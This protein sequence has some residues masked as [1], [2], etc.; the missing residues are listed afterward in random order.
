M[1]ETTYAGPHGELRTY[2]SV[3]PG[4]GP[5]PGVVLVHDILGMT[6]DLRNH[7]DRFAANGYLALAPDLYSWGRKLSCLKSTFA[8]LRARHGRA[9]DDIEAARVALSDRQDC[10]G[11]VGVIGYCMGGGFALL[12]APRF[13]FDA[14]SVNYGDVPQDAED[15]LAGTCPIVGSFGGMD[16]MPKPGTGA[17]L[18]RTLETLGVDHD[19][20][21]YPGVGH[22]FLND[23]QSRLSPIVGPVLA[24]VGHVGYDREA[25]E[26]AWGRILA[27]F[28]KHLASEG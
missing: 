5:W 1:T 2:L 13:G 8:A 10:T 18:A 20:K 28:G 16:R 14:S 25:A 24:K 3:P 26:D 7:A 4:P 12:C 6:T 15:V 23:H 22:S 19:V 9:F 17:R 11:R 21:E 27:F